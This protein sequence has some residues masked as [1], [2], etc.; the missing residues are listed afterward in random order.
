MVG[1]TDIHTLGRYP[2]GTS[3]ARDRH[4]EV[5][6]TQNTPK[7]FKWKTC[8]WSFV[9]NHSCTLKPPLRSK[10]SL[11]Q[12]WGGGGE[13]PFIFSVSNYEPFVGS[14]VVEILLQAFWQWSPCA[15]W[16]GGGKAVARAAVFSLPWKLPQNKRLSQ[17]PWRA[18]KESWSLLID[19][20]WLIPIYS[21]PH[22]FPV[23]LKSRKM[24][25]SCGRGRAP[26]I[27]SSAYRN[28]SRKTKFI[29]YF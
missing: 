4:S 18:T 15:S 9:F 22:I 7:F 24:G 2:T 11:R 14:G 26:L 23:S 6:F 16:G 17:L 20:V 13:I 21:N 5:N 8:K 25:L 10:Q 1:T 29:I 12:S 19:F 3:F 28:T 27:V